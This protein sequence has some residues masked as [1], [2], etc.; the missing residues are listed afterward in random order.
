M[1]G[2]QTC[3][4]PICVK[5]AFFE[6]TGVPGLDVRYR[7]DNSIGGNHVSEQVKTDIEGKVSKKYTPQAGTGAQGPGTVNISSSAILPESGEIWGSHEVRVFVNDINVE[8]ASGNKDKKPGISA[9]VHSIVLD[10]LNNGTAKD[11]NDYLGAVV[12]GKVLN[13]TI[14]KRSEERRVG[15]EC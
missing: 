6:G 13:G 5:A 12:P 15:K 8:L 10:R 14:I 2:V 11:Y 1:T 4:L 3:A 9:L 7:I